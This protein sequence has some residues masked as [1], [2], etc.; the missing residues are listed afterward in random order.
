MFALDKTTPVGR[1]PRRV[2]AHDHSTD[3]P[4]DTDLAAYM[5]AVVFNISGRARNIGKAC[6]A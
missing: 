6:G 2:A 1:W 3:H 5:F 4:V